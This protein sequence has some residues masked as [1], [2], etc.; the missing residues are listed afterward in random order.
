MRNLLVAVLAAT[1]GGGALALSSCGAEDAANVDAARAAV[2]TQR[3]GTARVTMTMKMEGA[4]LPASVTMGAEGVMDLSK[5]RGRI[6]FDFSRLLA[7]AGLPR[8]TGNAIDVVFDGSRLH[9]RPPE[10]DELRIPGGKSWIALD[11]ATLA[12]ALGISTE[13]LGE[14]ASPDP[15]SQLRLL[16]ATKGVEE[17]GEEE[18]D[19]VSTHHYRGTYRM[20]DVIAA[21][22]ERRRASV[23]RTLAS[24]ERLAD[25]EDLGFDKPTESEMWIDD[26]GVMRRMRANVKLPSRPGAPAGTMVMDQ[27]LHDFGAELDTTAPPASDTWDATAALRGLLGSATR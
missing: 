6:R 18:I 26:A 11:L 15:A 16:K 2:V 25:G 1:L 24:L 5:P 9:V 7:L 19:G 3:Q 22:P 21:L 13:G 10:L 27:R 17:V 4:G 8:G 12:K 20:S 23:R 14:L